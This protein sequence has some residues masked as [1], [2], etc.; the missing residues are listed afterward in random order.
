MDDG[1]E[2]T[3][4]LGR[5]WM[6]GQD[7][8]QRWISSEL[9]KEVGQATRIN[10]NPRQQRDR[11]LVCLLLRR[12]SELQAEQLLSDPA[13]ETRANVAH[14]Q[15][16]CCGK[17]ELLRDL[18]QAVSEFHMFNL[19]SK[20]TG[21]FFR[22]PCRLDQPRVDDHD[23]TGQGKRIDCRIVNHVK[24]VSIARTLRQRLPKRAHDASARGTVAQ[25]QLHGHAP[26]TLYSQLPLLLETH[27]VDGP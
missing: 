10:S 7:A 13:R 4:A 12:A 3:L 14:E 25:S 21:Q 18:S 26:E 22:T 2:R 6:R 9:A 1:S 5:S 17:P 11:P 19:V 15:C 23:A 16:Q 8:G 20:H 27:V 24:L